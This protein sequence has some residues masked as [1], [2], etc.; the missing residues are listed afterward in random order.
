MAMKLD[1]LSGKSVLLPALAVLSLSACGNKIDSAQEGVT[2]ALKEDPNTSALAVCQAQTGY[3]IRQVDPE[4]AEALESCATKLFRL[5]MPPAVISSITSGQKRC[6]DFKTYEDSCEDATKGFF[7][8]LAKRSMAD[9]ACLTGTD[10]SPNDQKRLGSR[11]EEPLAFCKE[12]IVKLS[13]EAIQEV[14]NGEDCEDLEPS[15]KELCMKATDPIFNLF[16]KVRAE[17]EGEVGTRLELEK[18]SSVRTAQKRKQS[19]QALVRSNQITTGLTKTADLFAENL[20][21]Y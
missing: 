9:E 7:D 13:Y 15:N 11:L 18:N 16:A 21:Q 20:P 12:E 17:E 2:Q 3:N 1:R 19:D 4:L 14:A 10:T 5:D 6:E 8:I